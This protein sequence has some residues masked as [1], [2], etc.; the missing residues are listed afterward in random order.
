MKR[1]VL[2][3]GLLLV[4]VF[5]TGCQRA[6]AL[7]GTYTAV[8]PPVASGEMVI[9]QVAFSGNKVTMISGDVQQT[10]D[11]KIKDGEF[12]LLT[13]FGNFSYAFEQKD[14]STITIDSVDYVRK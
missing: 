13:K 8:N 6:N 2:W 9:E 1:S 11:Y 7:E 5:L 12:T 10:V 4:L 3:I 14:A